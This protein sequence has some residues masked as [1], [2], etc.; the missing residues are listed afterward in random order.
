MKD[1]DLNYIGNNIRWLRQQKGFTIADL[2]SRIGMQPVPLGRIERCENTPSTT[3][4]YHLSKEFNISLDAFFSK[5]IEELQSHRQKVSKQPIQVSEKYF[6]GKLSP[7]TKK[8]VIEIIQSIGH[9]EEI[10]GVKK[11]ANIPLLIP[12]IADRH[13]IENLAAKVRQYMDIG[14][15]IVFDYFELFERKGLKAISL[16]LPKGV[17]SFSYYDHIYQNAFLFIN[18]KTT[19]ERQTFSLV[20]EL[21]RVLISS[22]SIQ[23]VSELFPEEDS[24]DLGE[25]PFTAHRAAR[26]FA[27]SFLMPKINIHNTVT[28]LNVYQKKWSYELLLR[29]KHRY[30]VSAQ[31]LLI[32][33]KELEQIEINAAEECDKKLMVYYEKTGYKEPGSSKRILIPNGRLWDLLLVGKNIETKR[34][35]IEQIHDIFLKWKLPYK[36]F[37]E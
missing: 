8:M 24:G 6:L 34:E 30:G 13:G 35:K 5:S 16:P 10:C 28:Q 12:F 15:G 7:S 1:T 31:A 9:L 20:Y 29:I 25:K 26:L 14:S 3:V 37:D 23:R 27:A 11:H 19:P 2:A 33:L 36:Q 4:L 18:S 21:G 32:R 17:N 22:Y